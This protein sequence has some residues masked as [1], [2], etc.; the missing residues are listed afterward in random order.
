MR[1]SA[2]KEVPGGRGDLLDVVGIS[3]RRRE[4]GGGQRVF[5]GLWERAQ[6][7]ARHPALGRRRLGVGGPVDQVH[8]L[9]IGGQDLDRFALTDADLVLFERR[10]VLGDPHGGGDAVTAAVAVLRRRKTGQDGEKTQRGGDR[11]KGGSDGG[12][13][14]EDN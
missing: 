12:R 14:D 10:V 2:G 9:L 7:L 5:Y 6:D 11:R 3:H 4:A 13:G 8:V 1:L